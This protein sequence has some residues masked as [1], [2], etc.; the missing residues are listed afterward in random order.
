MLGN[1]PGGERSGIG[2]GSGAVS[3]R[4]ECIYE[5]DTTNAVTLFV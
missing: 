3:T 5:R 2:R 4:R 1:L